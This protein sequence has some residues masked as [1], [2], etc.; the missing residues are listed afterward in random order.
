MASFSAR[1]QA[2]AT[3]AP[4]IVNIVNFIRLL[5]PRDPA[6]TQDVLYQTVASQIRL[7]RENRLGGTF[8]LQYDALMNPRYQQL[9]KSLPDSNFEI[10]AWWEITQPHV[11]RAGLRWRG[12]YPWDWDAN[13]DFSTGYTPKEREKLVDVYM[14]DF[15]KIY[16]RYPASVGSWFIDSYTLDYM[17]RKYGIVATCNC[18]D[19]IGTDGYTLWGGYWN[20]AY[21]PSRKNAYM[22]AQTAAQQLPVP[23]FRMLGSDPIRQYESGLGSNGQGV[24]TLEPVYPFGGGDAKWTNWYFDQFAHG[25]CMSY[26]YVQAG[27]ENSFTWPAMQKGLDIQFPLIARLRDSGLVKVQTL[28]QSGRWFKKQFRLTPPTAVTVNKDLDG[29]ERQTVWFDSRFFRLS[30]LWDKQTLRIRDLHLF[31][32]DISDDI[33]KDSATGSYALLTLP[34]VDGFVWSDKTYLAGLRL[35]AKIDGQEQELTGG[36]PVI[37]DAIPGK[38]HIAWPLRTGDATF[39]IDVDERHVKMHMQQRSGGTLTSGQKSTQWWLELTTTPN[40]VLPFTHIDP[41]AAYARFHGTDYTVHAAPGVFAPPAGGAALTIT[42]ENDSIVLDLGDHAPR[43]YPVELTTEHLSNPIGIDAEHPRFSWHIDDPGKTSQPVSYTLLVGTDS[44][45]I[46]RGEAGQWQHQGQDDSAIHVYAGKPLKPFTKYFCQVRLAT[47]KGQTLTSP[48]ASFETGMMQQGNWQGSWIGD[49]RDIRLKPAAYFRKGFNLDKKIISA[50]VY[51]AAAGLYELSINGRRVGDHMLDPM[52][53][54][55]DRRNLYVTYDVTSRLQEGDNAIGVTL[56]NGWYN[57]QSTAVWYFDKAPWRARPSFCLDLRVTYADG[58]TQTVSTDNTWKTTLSPIVFNSIYTGEHIDHRLNIPHWNEPGFIDTAWKDAIYRP[59]PSQHTTAQTTVPIR[60]TEALPAISVNKFSD[61]DYVFDIGRN[62]AGI[63]GITVQG[64]A[65]TV[66][67]LKHGEKLYANGH[68]DQS[69]IDVHYRPTDDSDPFQTDIYILDGDGNETFIPHFNYKGFQYVEVTSSRPLQ[70][71]KESLTGYFM[72][73]DVPPVGTIQTSNPIIDKI[74]AATNAS[75]LSNLYG[76]PTDCPQREKNGWTGDAQIAVETGL[77]NFDAITVYEK[78][79]ADLRDEQQPNGILPNIVPTSGWG[80]DWA[81]GPDWTSAL[82]I[83]PWNVY[84]FYGDDKLLRDCYDNIRRYVDHIA[85]KYPDGLTSWGLGDWIPVRSQTPVEFT[86][87]CYY[88]ADVDILARAARL[89]HHEADYEK[90][91]ALAAKIKRAFNDKYLNRNAGGY[92]KN[93]QTELSAA[94][95][96]HLVPAEFIPRTAAALA[97][98][99][100][101]DSVK[102]DVGL[103]GTKTILNALSENGYNDLAYQLASDTAYPSWGH[104]IVHGATTLLE[105]WTIES[106]SDVS[107]NHIMFGEIGA[108]FYKGLG[109]IFPDTAAPGF[110]HI[111]LRPHIPRGLKA[112]TATHESP[113]GEIVSGWTTTADGVIHYHATIPPG[114]TADLQLEIAG[115]LVK[116]AGLT[117]G[118]TQFDYKLK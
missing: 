112:F 44:T 87:T 32:E 33:K 92:D 94:L 11:E 25:A 50:R 65:G 45:A 84:L 14:E 100:K 34:F 36:D 17:Y 96:W 39:I 54:R 37:T 56:G 67:R 28:G 4:R 49:T 117:A 72:H 101:A 81:N 66:I 9:L 18:K 19:Q 6:I 3:P 61:T 83:I 116:T 89:F 2:A 1:S 10:G 99:L 13:V 53:T 75:Y 48:V 76:Y 106:K 41:H 57:L 63:S 85:E 21:Y 111:R 46:T 98:R 108:W 60:I 71:T 91:T 69:N 42:P 82:V 70:L 30:I 35:K 8:L 110:R 104:W 59:E 95:Y 15:K 73:S 86:S 97:A 12:R 43:P 93:Y 107:W 105:N 23:V 52:Y 62:I 47:G 51:I 16:G 24:I 22:P 74:W 103:L 31:D 26:A 29:G 109:G 77:Y 115:K 114:A 68:V 27:Q 5:E 7:M 38:L 40:A 118:V 102:L 20:Q 79:L 88:Y 78:W 80:Y 113:Y 90:Y 64:P 55:F 58:T